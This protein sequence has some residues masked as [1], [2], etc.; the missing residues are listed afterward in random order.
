MRARRNEGY[1]CYENWDRDLSVQIS[2]TIMTI[3]INLK[4]AFNS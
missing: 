1:R 4:D 2:E 3:E